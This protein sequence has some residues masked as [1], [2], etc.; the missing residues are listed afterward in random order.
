MNRAW[1][2]ETW[3]TDQMSFEQFAKS[4][5]TPPKKTMLDFDST[6]DRADGMQVDRF[7]HDI[8]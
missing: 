3:L 4:Y 5:P 2:K 8:K 7:F 1:R 6:D